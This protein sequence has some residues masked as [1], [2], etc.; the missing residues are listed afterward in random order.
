MIDK[1]KITQLIEDKL[2]EDQFIVEIEITTSNQILVTLDGE[3]GITID[4]CVQIS[5]LVEGSI[6]REV[7]DFELQVSSSGLGQAFKVRRQFV[8]NIGQEVE[9]VLTNGEKLEG[10]IK[11]IENDEFELETIKR[12]KVEGHK[13]KQLITRLH[14]IAFDEA[15]TVKNIIKF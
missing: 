13:K 4:H 10:T 2:T 5:R 7:D 14:R 1:N 6:D 15:K 11:S 3:N 8:K 12:E 9:V